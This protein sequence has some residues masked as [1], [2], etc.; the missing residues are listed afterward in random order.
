[1]VICMDILI[2]GNSPGSAHRR[3]LLNVAWD[4]IIRLNDFSDTYSRIE[5][6]DWFVT[7]ETPDELERRF[8]RRW[9]L[10]PQNHNPIKARRWES[11]GVDGRITSR[12]LQRE[13]TLFSSA[14]TPLSGTMAIAWAL[15]NFRAANVYIHGFELHEE[16]NPRWFHDAGVE[17]QFGGHHDAVIDAAQIM[18]WIK[19]GR[20]HP[21]GLLR[22]G[23]PRGV[24]G[25]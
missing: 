6:T 22:L 24:R 14:D 9:L 13:L 20:V 2:I 19:S 18:F 12:Q 16:S 23:K 17:K 4:R 7:P 10:V 11:L 15:Q 25:E 1:M 8:E 21:L 3:N 5:C